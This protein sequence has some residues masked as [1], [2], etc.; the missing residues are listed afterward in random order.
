M[1]VVAAID[2]SLTSPGVCI[3]PDHHLYCFKQRQRE[4]SNHRVTYLPAIPPPSDTPEGTMIRYTHIVNHIVRAISSAAEKHGT[5]D[6][7]VFLEG[8]AFAQRQQSG[9]AYKLREL[10]GILKYK[11]LVVKGWKL[12]VIG[13]GQWRKIFTGK[14]NT[15][16]GDTLYHVCR[17]LGVGVN[18]LY[19]DFYFQEPPSLSTIESPSAADCNKL[20]IPCPLQ[21]C[22]DA[23]GI[24]MAG[25]APEKCVQQNKC[26][27][28]KRKRSASKS[29]KTARADA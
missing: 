25:Y 24:A 14:G 20:R 23:F 26:T 27:G 2:L 29:C 12:Q 10:T 8:Y 16:K 4:H 19:A 15:K 11:I 7:Q 18:Q 13:I 1:I 5:D 3:E 22:C 17:H 9:S 28:K 21:D 6:V